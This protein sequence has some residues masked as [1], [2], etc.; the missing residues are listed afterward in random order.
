MENNKNIKGFHLDKMECNHCDEIHK[1]GDE[2]HNIL[3]EMENEDENIERLEKAMEYFCGTWDKCEG[4]KH[5]LLLT[6]DD[7]IENHIHEQ[8]V[9]DYKKLLDILKK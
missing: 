9:E 4:Y 2:V 1:L 5:A 7:Q 8:N 3:S 6:L